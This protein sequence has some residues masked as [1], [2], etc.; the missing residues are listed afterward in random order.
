MF[1]KQEMRIAQKQLEA[2]FKAGE[3][4]AYDFA[5]QRVITSWMA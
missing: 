3:I 2:M 5:V 1:T 4:S